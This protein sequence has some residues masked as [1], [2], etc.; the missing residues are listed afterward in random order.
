MSSRPFIDYLGYMASMA[1]DNWHILG[2][3]PNSDAGLIYDVTENDTAL[4]ISKAPYA[5]SSIK[6]AKHL[7]DRGAYV[8][9]ITDGISSPLCQYCNSTFFIA[10]ETPQ[11]FTSHAA[12]L[13]LLETLI[14]IVVGK[15]GEAVSNRIANIEATS[16]AV[17]EYYPKTEQLNQ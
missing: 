10:T 4:I 1:F 9:G 17:G 14:G 5:A 6:A 12:T 7:R 8:I 15:G 13:V 2:D 11:F 16:L 3:G